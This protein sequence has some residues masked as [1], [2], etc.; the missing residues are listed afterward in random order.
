MH[1][2]VYQVVDP[3][4]IN[5]EL[6]SEQIAGLGADPNYLISQELAVPEVA[7]AGPA[8]DVSGLQASISK[9]LVQTAPAAAPDNIK[10]ESS[11]YILNQPLSEAIRE[12][13]DING[14]DPVE[15]PPPPPPSPDTDPAESSPADNTSG[16]QSSSD[17]VPVYILTVDP[18]LD[19]DGW[20][21]GES[22]YTV[23]DPDGT[24]HVF[25][26]L[27]EAEEYLRQ[28]SK[29]HGVI[30]VGQNSTG[31]E[32]VY[33]ADV[34]MN[35]E[36]IVDNMGNGDSPNGIDKA[37]EWI[38]NNKDYFFADLSYITDTPHLDALDENSTEDDLINALGK[39][40]EDTVEGFDDD[41]FYYEDE[42]GFWVLDTNRLESWYERVKILCA[43]LVMLQMLKKAKHEARNIVEQELNGWVNGKGLDTAS[44][45]GK[46]VQNRLG[47]VKMAF[48][49][50]LEDIQ[51]H[52]TER[53]EEMVEAANKKLDGCGE[54][55]GDFLIGGWIQADML[56]ELGQAANDYYK[57][58]KSTLEFMR[59][60]GGSSS[61]GDT[62]T[63]DI[64]EYLDQMEYS[65]YSGLDSILYE[66]DNDYL[67]LDE[68]RLQVLRNRFYLSKN[69]RKAWNVV[70]NSKSEM[71]NLVHEEMTGISGREKSKTAEKMQELEGDHAEQLF[72]TR[73]QMTQQKM[74]LHNQYRYLLQKEIAARVQW[75][76]N[77]CS[78]FAMIVAMIVGGW[79]GIIIGLVGAAYRLGGAAYADSAVELYEPDAPSYDPTVRDVNTGN[80]VWDVINE[81]DNM[82]DQV[83]N[84]VSG[85]M[86]VGTNDDLFAIDY[87]Q[88]AALQ[89]KLTRINNAK[90]AILALYKE[91]ASV[92]K[93]VHMEMTTIGSREMS[94]YVTH[95]NKID[96]FKLQLLSF[97]LNEYVTAKN[98]SE[99]QKKEMEAAIRTFIISLAFAAGGA[100][101]GGAVGGS[102]GAA[103]GYGIGN[104]LGTLVSELMNNIT[105]GS[106]GASFGDADLPPYLASL[107][108][109]NQNSTE[110]RLNQ[111]EMEIYEDLLA[112][113]I[114][115]DV[116]DGYWGVNASHAAQ[117]RA[118]LGRIANIKSVMAS[119]QKAKAD[120]RNLVHMEM[121]NVSGRRSG[122]YVE[123]VNRAEAETSLRLF[124]Y[125]IQYLDQRVQVQ[126]RAR[127][128]Q[129]AVTTSGIK[130]AVSAVVTVGFS[131]GG[132][133]GG[134]S[135]LYYLITPT[136]QLL[137]SVVDLIANLVY[138]R[139][140][141][142]K[143]GDYNVAQ[144]LQGIKKSNSPNATLNRL[145][146]LER[147]AYLDITQNLIE[148]LGAGRWGLSSGTY[149]LFR[150]RMEKIFNIKDAVARARAAQAEARSIVH[151]TMTGMG[152]RASEAMAA[153][154]TDRM[155]AQAL[156]RDLMRNL[157]TIVQRH[158]QMKAAERAAIVS[159]VMVGWAAL[160]W[161]LS[162]RSSGNY[163]KQKALVK[164][165][166][167]N[168]KLIA[169]ARDI[170]TNLRN[171]H[172][173]GKIDQAT[174]K[175]KSEKNKKWLGALKNTDREMQDK[176]RG[177]RKISKKLGKIEYAVSM[178]EA[179]TVWATG[180][181]VDT[182]GK[183]KKRKSKAG[184]HAA[185]VSRAST[186]TG[187][188]SGWANQVT[189]T[190]NEA[191]L[192]GI[193]AGDTQL[194]TEAMQIQ[195]QKW[196]EL[197]NTSK[198]VAKST[199]K[200][201]RGLDNR[202]KAAAMLA[203]R[204][205]NKVAVPHAPVK[206]LNQNNGADFKPNDPKSM[207]SSKALM[208]QANSIMARVEQAAVE[209]Q[210]VA[211]NTQAVENSAKVASK[212]KVKTQD[213]KK[214]LKQAEAALKEARQAYKKA[215][216][217]LK[218][219]RKEASE[220][221]AKVGATIK[222][223]DDQIKALTDQMKALQ[224]KAKGKPD[225]VTAA[226]IKELKGQIDL[227]KLNITALK[228]KAKQLNQKVKTAHEQL[229]AAQQS[230][231]K[232]A[233]DVNKIKAKMLNPKKT[234]RVNNA[235]ATVQGAVTHVD[236]KSNGKSRTNPYEAYKQ[237]K[238]E[239]E[240]MASISNKS[241]V[242]SAA[243]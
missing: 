26:S 8:V 184:E 6:Q 38:D 154:T 222:R 242:M 88:I 32:N 149:A 39:E 72:N 12:A 159:A 150:H 1:S 146:A 118:K 199:A 82:S 5:E 173:A 119:V 137:N 68:G 229:K 60:I 129:K 10:E 31:Y 33:Y 140:G 176:L 113:G 64:N 188:K 73:L 111:L 185:Q 145:D 155:V 36:K 21:T 191:T 29:E 239:Q 46:W 231:K 66:G 164:K 79:A 127:N 217:G 59:Q 165:I 207:P 105:Y 7:E 198:G 206:K 144:T 104:I 122:E 95:M 74:G 211:K 84:Q 192:S 108:N 224:I 34:Y 67:E 172:K 219:A 50:L 232:A 240:Q 65:A 162:W 107:R 193:A 158:N 152:G 238:E 63:G 189:E 213:L 218:A 237:A 121:T 120:M 169:R 171:D 167:A 75:F 109:T 100:G 47:K 54:K 37:K 123:G 126:N 212:G 35:G 85:E 202:Q 17:D 45:I 11:N 163:V 183:G 148:E 91:K 243:A 194:D 175:T 225:A 20:T 115:D 160:S 161:Y 53:Y 135:R 55:F 216:N 151:S 42:N 40:L 52:N 89:L 28:Q 86:I 92:R 14:S 136:I 78:N 114:C 221:N 139:T 80:V 208:D 182:A 77:I 93:L 156:M 58:T 124:N 4:R 195:G 241:K 143:L 223:Y 51:E 190:E 18:I 166:K 233:M 16:S 203:R 210:K 9:S 13:I 2:N 134:V 180:L 128:A 132:Y 15:P 24:Q 90:Q 201:I 125:L 43:L 235:G 214:L 110:A 142:G 103:I 116:G 141:L 19:E 61:Y 138:S 97:V 131:M 27:E 181:L 106:Y 174:F 41:H 49:K 22:T 62:S 25:N 186:D 227:L 230:M 112:N 209:M 44:I 200:F 102:S 98:F 157:Q 179:A 96:F 234:A 99:I 71:R 197:V 147:E 177:I 57:A 48:G 69:I 56:R 30:I 215:F 83:Y 196:D 23:T 220:Y 204:K 236:S 205:A 87:K 81:T 170:Q 70:N 101:G 178:L 130:A 133:F 76:Y 226:K 187:Q 117:L 228:E 153:Y 3:Q 168:N 94:D